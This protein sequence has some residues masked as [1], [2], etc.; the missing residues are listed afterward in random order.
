MSL[1]VEKCI[2]RQQA[3]NV[4]AMEAVLQEKM[5]DPENGRALKR[6]LESPGSSSERNVVESSSSG[7][8]TPTS[9][10]RSSAERQGAKRQHTSL[11][12][13]EGIS[14]GD[15]TNTVFPSDVDENA[16]LEF[17]NAEG[18]R[19]KLEVIDSSS[20]ASGSE[21]DEEENGK[22]GSSG[23]GKESVPAD[24]EYENDSSDYESEGNESDISE[25][26]FEESTSAE[27]ELGFD[28]Y[29]PDIELPP[30]GQIKVTKK[31]CSQVR[32]YLKS[33]G[34]VAFLDLFLPSGPTPEDIITLTRL[35]G[36]EPKRLNRIYASSSNPLH[37]A[38]FF[39]REAIN[40]VLKSRTR[41]QDFYTIQN[42]CDALNKAENVLVLTGAG[43][44]TSLGIP[45]FR[46]SQGFYSK[47]KNL[48]LDDPQDVFSLELFRRDPSV[49]YSI[50]Y[51]I[52]PPEHS[53]TPL[54][55]FIK[56]LQDKGK[57]LRN[58]TQNIDNLEANAGVTPEKLVQ[59]HGS[60]AT[61]SCVTCKYK[62]PGETLYPNLRSKKIAYCPFCEN[63]R[64]N[65][66]R[67]FEK[68]EDEGGF[69]S[70]YND[71]ESFGVMKP[72]IT[73]FGENLPDRYHNTIKEDVRKCDLLICIGTS[74]KVAPVSEIVNR[75]PNE[76][77]QILINRDPINHCEFD[78]ELLGY[79]DQA[80]TW[81][82]GDK[83]E[84][85]IKHK[86]FEQ[87]LH[88]G[89]ELQVLDEEFGRYRITD[90][91]ERVQLS[92]K[93][94]EAA[95]AEAKLKEEESLLIPDDQID[96]KAEVSEESEVVA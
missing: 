87:I 25:F 31:T 32:K 42:V 12:P 14:V 36:F 61:A 67:K 47:M 41:L 48:G 21:D 54:H 29:D 9:E 17:E 16:V 81:L 28:L 37:S 4:T 26:Q 73:F 30:L 91:N 39:L 76:V 49:F 1:L 75:V 51:M 95:K 70:R 55:G 7:S 2:K 44:S 24:Q 92:L 57:L 58:Y 50:A 62:I 88:S 85:E 93:K 74:L 86:D 68:L 43:I 6:E 63:E 89:L 59:C 35:L 10:K 64:K 46:S 56:L 72:D 53:F 3:S 80:I 77:P 94:L 84:W 90:A 11:N 82:C 78:V 71:I 8:A 60:F 83:I 19:V 33:E 5:E 18:E 27:D 96:I 65:M 23:G 15:A 40:R 66:Q 79:C 45:D 52:L 22:S 13:E 38:I 69:S 20:S 34:H